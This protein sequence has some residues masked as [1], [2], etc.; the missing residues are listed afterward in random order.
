MRYGQENEEA[1]ITEYL[2]S[3]TDYLGNGIKQGNLDKVLD[4]I[5]DYIDLK[6]ALDACENC[7]SM[8]I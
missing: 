3:V 5:D 4:I 6:E 2:G 7:N 1:V 8:D